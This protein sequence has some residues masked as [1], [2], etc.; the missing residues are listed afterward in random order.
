MP[1]WFVISSQ[2]NGVKNVLELA[3]QF[4]E[5]GIVQAAEPDFIENFKLCNINVSDTY[6]NDQWGG[7][8]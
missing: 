4:Y 8:K 5:S 1:L 3:N 7:V 2:N 6:W